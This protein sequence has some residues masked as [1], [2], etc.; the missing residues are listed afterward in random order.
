M[1]V[2]EGVEGVEGGDAGAPDREQEG[3]QAL[4]G[5]GAVGGA[6]DG[7]EGLLQSPGLGDQW[8]VGE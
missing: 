7:T 5:G 3:V 8:L 2:G 6:V 1:P 4:F